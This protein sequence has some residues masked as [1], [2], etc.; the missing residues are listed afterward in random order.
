LFNI[1]FFHLFGLSKKGRKTFQQFGLVR[2]NALSA[3]YISFLG[4]QIKSKTILLVL[5]VGI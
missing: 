2:K 3:I 1:F 4:L 5:F